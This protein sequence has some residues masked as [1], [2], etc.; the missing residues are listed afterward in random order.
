MT[1]TNSNFEMSRL[2][3]SYTAFDGFTSYV[4]GEAAKLIYIK[5]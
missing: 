5:F 1:L 2:F 4:T 3:Y